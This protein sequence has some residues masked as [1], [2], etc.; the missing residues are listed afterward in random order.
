MSKGYSGH[1]NGTKGSKYAAGSS[2]FMD[3]KDAFS[4]NIKRRKD[5]DVNG[6]FD[7]IAHG[8]PTSIEIN[9]NGTRIMVNHRTLAR[10]LK[11]AKWYKKQ[12]I[13]LLSCSTGKLNDGF[14]QNLANKLNVPVSAPTYI[15]WAG[16]SGRHFV[17][18][19]TT[20]NGHAAAD[21]SKPGKFKTFYPKR[22]KK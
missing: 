9:S 17:A 10:L 6:F 7:V 2:Y 14:A 1:F 18:G 8:S 16:P 21:I 4:I 15:L 19:V 3:S 20:I 12:G 11:N 13:R 22:R 5:I